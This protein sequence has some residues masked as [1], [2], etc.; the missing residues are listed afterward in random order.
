MTI[1]NW[2]IIA[3]II[4]A[5]MLAAATLLAPSLAEVVK[6]R[7]SQ[8]KLT[9]I[10]NQPKRLIGE[11]QIARKALRRLV[12]SMGIL[13]GMGMYAYGVY[14]IHMNKTVDGYSV[15][16]MASGVVIPAYCLCL[17]LIGRLVDIVNEILLE[18]EDVH[19]VALQNQRVLISALKVSFPDNE[20]LLNNLKPASEPID[21]IFEKLE[22]NQDVVPVPPLHKN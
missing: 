15:L 14:R 20:T 5:I 21:A 9:P 2:L 10:T 11:I 22:G 1:D 12:Y 19:L 3:T 6:V 8:P 13:C 16:F 18:Q 4:S 17:G 7:V